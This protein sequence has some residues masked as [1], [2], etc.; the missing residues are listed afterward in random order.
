VERE[1]DTSSVWRRNVAYDSRSGLLTAPTELNIEVI[2]DLKIALAPTGKR[3]IFLRTRSLL[4]NRMWRK[5]IAAASVAVSPLP[6]MAGTISKWESE[7]LEFKPAPGTKETTGEFLFYEPEP[8][9]S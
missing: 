6:S 3:P 2:Q 5:I 4:L 9:P 8:V 7:S 1:E